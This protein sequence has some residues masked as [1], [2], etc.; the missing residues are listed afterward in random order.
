MERT[1]AN[2]GAQTSGR[3]ILEPTTQKP[4]NQGKCPDSNPSNQRS[5]PRKSSKSR[6][7]LEFLALLLYDRKRLRVCY[8]AEFRIHNS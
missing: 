1:N 5:K 8:P 2:M 7:S 4:P 3:Q 6:R